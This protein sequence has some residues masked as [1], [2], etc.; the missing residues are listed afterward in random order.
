MCS[1]ESRTNESPSTSPELA[2]MPPERLERE[3]TELAAQR[4]RGDV[5]LV[6]PAR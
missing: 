6:A 3:I 2:T 4:Q 1:I 5:P